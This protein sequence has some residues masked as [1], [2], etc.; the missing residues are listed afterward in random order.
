[1]LLESRSH[2]MGTNTRELTPA[3]TCRVSED[4]DTDFAF[5]TRSA[6]TNNYSILSNY[7]SCEWH[8]HHE[9]IIS[10]TSH[11]NPRPQPKRKKRP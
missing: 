9:E 5:S 10:Y 8:V 2:G 11:P 1:M 3:F 6:R 4:K 7:L